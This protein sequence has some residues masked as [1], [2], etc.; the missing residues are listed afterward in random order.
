[1]CFKRRTFM[2]RG[3]TGNGVWM[4]CAEYHWELRGDRECLMEHSS[5]LRVKWGQG[6]NHFGDRGD[7]T[8][9][10]PA[11]GC[12][13]AV[14]EAVLLFVATGRLNRVHYLDLRGVCLLV[15]YLGIDGMLD[16]ILDV[17]DRYDTLSMAWEL[18][19]LQRSL[20]LPAIDAMLCECMAYA[21]MDPLALGECGVHHAYSLEF[22]S[23][24]LQ[25][26]LSPT[27]S[28]ALPKPQQLWACLA[29]V[30]EWGA[31]SM[32]PPGGVGTCMRAI[33]EVDHH[34]CVD[35]MTAVGPRHPM[36]CAMGCTFVQQQGFRYFM[37][38][39][40]EPM[41]RV[42]LHCYTGTINSVGVGSWLLAASSEGDVLIFDTCTM[43]PHPVAW[44]RNTHWCIDGVVVV[45]GNVCVIYNGDTLVKL[46]GV[47]SGRRG[48]LVLCVKGF[49]TVD[50]VMATIL[51]R[52]TTAFLKSPRLVASGLDRTDRFGV[53]G[54]GHTLYV[55][56]R[57]H[58]TISVMS[59]KVHVG[60]YRPAM[61]S[62]L[63]GRGVPC[64]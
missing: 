61:T 26:L 24:I 58:A 31:R 32:V 7:D 55:P 25:V 18:H 33:R 42:H 54:S 36:Q 40:V 27:T 49:P 2:P 5:M 34:E 41:G 38:P 10:V 8:F 47:S 19:Q 3:D 13:Q 23:S 44:Y 9:W 63:R 43:H 56:D 57:T 53:G 17:W 22:V 48:R 30:C 59:S 46:R 45:D 15:D 28:A 12:S 11:P 20:Y 1:L 6:D 29:L 52:Q 16:N 62:L 35:T 4:R 37:W 50:S 39:R 64:D 21:C 14:G 51:L 60:S